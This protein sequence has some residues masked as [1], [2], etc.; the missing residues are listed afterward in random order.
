MTAL[1][2]ASR[3]GHHDIVKA[4]LGA[5][6]NVNIQKSGKEPFSY[7]YQSKRLVLFIGLLVIVDSN[8]FCFDFLLV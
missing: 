8:F 4:L 3:S 5:G 2:M 6:A 1:T 7:S